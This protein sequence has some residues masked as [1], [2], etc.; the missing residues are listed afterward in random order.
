[1]KTILQSWKPLLLWGMV[2]VVVLMVG[3]FIDNSGV[4]GT[5]MFLLMPYFAALAATIPILIVKRFGTGLLTF[6][7]YVLIGFY[8]LYYFD[9]LQRPAMVGL[10]AVFAYA[11]SG[12]VIGAAMD[13]AYLAAGRLPER[14]QAIVVGAAM[15][16]MTFVVTLVGLGYLYTPTS[17]MAAHVRFFDRQWFFSL[18]WMVVNGA[19]GGYTAYAFWKR[20]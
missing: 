8:P 11:L 18:P 13:V 12:F 6:L 14:T 10:W 19:F 1:M 2:L 16:A 15:Q 4:S 9:W 20:V 17:D 7:P 5:C 3:A